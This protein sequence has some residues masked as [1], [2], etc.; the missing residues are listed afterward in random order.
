MARGLEQVSQDIVSGEFRGQRRVALSD[1]D[2][3]ELADWNE[4]GVSWA[5]GDSR[6]IVLTC[7][8]VIFVELFL[9]ARR[10]LLE[11]LRV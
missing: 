4:G 2:E 1:Q 9:E 3:Q 6:E 7:Q 11:C 8:V 5:G 10:N